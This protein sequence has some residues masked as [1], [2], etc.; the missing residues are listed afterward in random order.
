MFLLKEMDDQFL[1]DLLNSL[2]EHRGSQI[3]LTRCIENIN[4]EIEAVAFSESV[5][6]L[7]TRLLFN[8]K[9]LLG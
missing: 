2:S 7:A 1:D 4:Y 9:L 6:Q 3:F 5:A 8:L